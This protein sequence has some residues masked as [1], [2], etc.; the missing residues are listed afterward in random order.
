[1]KK[2][3]LSPMGC[4]LAALAGLV[5]GTL[6]R[7]RALSFLREDMIL[8]GGKLV[9]TAQWAVFMPKFFYVGSAVSVVIGLIALFTLSDANRRYI[10][11][12]PRWQRFL[13]WPW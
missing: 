4:F 3:L 5:L 8:S 10:A 12:L 11:Q 7:F 13:F 6:V 9:S 1:M 2:P